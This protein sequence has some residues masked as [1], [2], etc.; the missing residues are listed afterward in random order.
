MGLACIIDPTDNI[1]EY[2]MTLAQMALKLVY[3]IDTHSHE[4]YSSTA[5]ILAQKTNGLILMSKSVSEQMKFDILV[6]DQE[7][8]S[9][10]EIKLKF[11]HTPGHTTDSMCVLLTDRIFTGDT[12]L[13]GRCGRIDAP[14]ADGRKLY[15][16]IFQKILIL[17]NDLIIYPGHDYKNNINTVLGYERVNNPFLKCESAEEFIK[18][19]EKFYSQKQGEGQEKETTSPLMHQMCLALEDYLTNFYND[20]NIIAPSELKKQMDKGEKILLLDVRSDAEFN[21]GHIKGSINIPIEQISIRID[22]LPY[23]PS[24]QIV[25]ICTSGSRSV[26][27]AFF[28]R[29][30]GYNNVKNLDY[31]ILGWQSEDYPLAR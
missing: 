13:I 14:G 10:G 19:T 24:L 6:E 31:G 17:S 1:Q 20:W 23:E 22:E 5:E 12:L 7:E 28:L 15:E 11:I 26:Y 27:A 30:Y 25:V 4:D 3:I 16:S 29:A 18:F 21:M 9:L 2:L 8:I